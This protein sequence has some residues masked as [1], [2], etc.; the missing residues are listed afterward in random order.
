MASARGI[1]RGTSPSKEF[2]AVF[3]VQDE[4][5]ELALCVGT[6][7]ALVWGIGLSLYGLHQGSDVVSWTAWGVQLLGGVCACLIVPPAFVR[8]REW[9]LRI[10][11]PREPLRQRH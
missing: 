6:V 8:G 9:V 7:A 5:T 11:Q 1:S 2:V 10:Q 4:K 3:K